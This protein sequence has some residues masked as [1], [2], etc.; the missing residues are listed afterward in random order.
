MID[1]LRV[2]KEQS[3]KI[4]PIKRININLVEPV[5]WTVHK[6]ELLRP[7]TSHRFRNQ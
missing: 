4:N 2:E 7:E 6:Y 5:D 3:L 1:K